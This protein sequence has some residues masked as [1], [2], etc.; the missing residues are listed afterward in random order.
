MKTNWNTKINWNF[1]FRNLIRILIIAFWLAWSGALYFMVA[2]FIFGNAAYLGI[3]SLIFYTLVVSV[4]TYVSYFATK[5]LWS[6]F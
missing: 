6:K 2:S 1:H 4:G 5:Y 3:F